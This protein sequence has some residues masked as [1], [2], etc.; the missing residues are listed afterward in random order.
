[1]IKKIVTF[2]ETDIEKHKFHGH[3]N[4]ILVYDVD[5]NKILVSNKVSFGKKSFRYFIGYKDRK[6]VRPLCVIV[7]KMSAY[8]RDIDKTKYMSFLI[9]KW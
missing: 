2:G 8:R 4:P 5:I 3:K 6:K 9:K 1:M 7:D